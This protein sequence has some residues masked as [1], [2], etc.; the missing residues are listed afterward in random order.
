MNTP[1]SARRTAG[2]YS[3]PCQPRCSRGLTGDEV[4]Q[5]E[6]DLVSRADDPDGM[7]ASR[8][9]NPVG[10]DAHARRPAQRLAEAVRWPRRTAGSRTPLLNPNSTFSAAEPNMPIASITRGE[11]RSD[12]WPLKNCPIP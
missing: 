5:A 7:A 1:V 11:K 9:G 8:D 3:A 10:R 6:R 12:N 4:R 2:T